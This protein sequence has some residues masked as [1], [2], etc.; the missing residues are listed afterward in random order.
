MYKANSIKSTVP[1]VSRS[2]CT[3]KIESKIFHWNLQFGNKKE[4]DTRIGIYKLGLCHLRSLSQHLIRGSIFSQRSLSFCLFNFGD[5]YWNQF[6]FLVR[7]RL[8]S[9]IPSLY[10]LPVNHLS[11]T[12]PCIISLYH[13][14][15]QKLFFVFFIVSPF[16]SLRLPS[17]S[18]LKTP[19]DP[20]DR[21]D[22]LFPWWDPLTKS[23]LVSR[24]AG[25]A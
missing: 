4:K 17:I 7:D 23:I 1:Q 15:I 19:Q 9:V 14:S 5:F 8:F 21:L 20:Q 12:S 10:P 16:T 22:D 6:P 3:L 18:S 25:F 24:M 11:A 13:L 2:R